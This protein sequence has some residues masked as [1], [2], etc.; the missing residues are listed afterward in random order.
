[1]NMSRSLSQEG[2]AITGFEAPISTLTSITG[3]ETATLIPT[4]EPAGRFE[5]VAEVQGIASI[6][7]SSHGL[8]VALQLHPQLCIAA[9]LLV[10]T[11]LL[12]ITW[13]R[14]VCLGNKASNS[15]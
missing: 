9:I 3:P 8:Y 6:G 10:V 7:E 13:H 11:A 5:E 14:Y 2:D 12:T 1:M 4:Q 15:I